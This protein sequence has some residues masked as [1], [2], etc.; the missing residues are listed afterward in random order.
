[1]TVY[2]AL[3]TA[4]IVAAV[5]GEPDRLWVDWNDFD[6]RESAL[7]LLP[8]SALEEYSQVVE[9]LGRADP[10]I[11]ETVVAD[12]ARL[13]RTAGPK[14]PDSTTVA[15]LELPPNRSAR[16]ERL[17]PVLRAIT[18]VGWNGHAAAAALRTFEREAFARKRD[19]LARHPLFV[20]S[21]A[22]AFERKREQLFKLIAAGGTSWAFDSRILAEASQ[23]AAERAQKTEFVTEDHRHMSPRCPAILAVTGLERLRDLQGRAF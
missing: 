23:H 7:R 13:I 3:D 20:P 22:Q 1:V 9:G 10:G 15:S 6:K 8:K 17:I 16:L 12:G 19:F 11:L 2:L 18:P 5:L 14:A 21:D 4:V